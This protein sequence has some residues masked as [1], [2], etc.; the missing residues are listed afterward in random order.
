[1]QTMIIKLLLG[2]RNEWLTEHFVQMDLVPLTWC[3]FLCANFTLWSKN[4]HYRSTIGKSSLANVSWW[5]VCD[6][7]TQVQ[8]TQVHMTQMYMSAWVHLCM[9]VAANGSYADL[10][11]MM[12]S[13]LHMLR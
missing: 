12:K 9:R 13:M 5:S 8:I 2:F 3:P 11:Q 4:P 7:M 6:N 1:M 10:K